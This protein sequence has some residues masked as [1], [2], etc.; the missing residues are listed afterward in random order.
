VSGIADLRAGIL[1]YVTIGVVSPVFAGRARELAVLTEAFTVTA[2]RT[3]TVVLLGAEAGGGKSRLASEFVAQVAGRAQVLTGGCVELTGPGLPYAPF[4]AALRELVRDRG[5][6]AVTALLPGPGA[7]ELAALLPGLGVAP[8]GAEPETARARLFELLLAL[9]ETLA[10]EQPVVLIIED[11]HW[12]DRAT[13]DLLSFVAR[14]LRNAAVLLVV[15]FRSD[16]LHRDDLLA[17]LLAG[18][19]R[20]DG[21]TRLELLRLS[22]DQV[23]T[24]LEGILGHPPAPSVTSAVHRRGGGNPLF[25]EALVSRDGTVG[26]D[27]PS[28]LRE[29]LLAAVKS[30]PEQTQQLLRTAAVGGSWIGHSLLG[31]VTGSVAAPIAGNLAEALTGAGRWDEALEI[32]EE[33]LRLELPPRG[34]VHALLIRAEIALGRG[35]LGTAQRALSEVRVLPAGVRAEDTTCCR[36]PGW[37]SITRL[38]PAIWPVPWPPRAHFPPTAR[39]PIRA[40]SGRCWPALCGRALRSPR[41]ARGPDPPT[42]PSC[43]RTWSRGPGG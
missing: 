12:A 9:L 26:T 4:V 7:G 39:M 1:M 20:M 42:Q 28:T 38:P 24:Q 34:R 40:T 10:E 22:R 15:T 17:S 31:A 16:S 3:P 5:A 33:I 19:E 13:C 41:S 14:N 21:V 11:V 18:L 32:V 29:L 43:A 36:W 6:A 27:L 25:T 35:D 23:A 37:T 30:L 2:S 8:S